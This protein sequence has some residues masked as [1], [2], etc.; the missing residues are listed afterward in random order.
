MEVNTRIQV[1]H[2]VTE[3]LTGIDLVIDS[4]FLL[5]RVKSCHS[6]KK[7][8][9]FLGMSFN[10]EL[11]PKILRQNFAPSPGSLE[12]YF[13]PGGPHVRVDSACYSGYIYSAQL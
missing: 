5:R 8:F 2:T 12:Y 9:N 1:E 3:E 4:K 7:I 13:P 10:L 6:N 11:M